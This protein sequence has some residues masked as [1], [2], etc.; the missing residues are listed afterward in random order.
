MRRSVMLAAAV[1]AVACGA[2]ESGS[3]ATPGGAALVVTGSLPLSASSFTAVT[4]GATCQAGS[5]TFGMAYT[6]LFASDQPGICA[7][8]QRNQDRANARSVDLTVVRIDPS[9]PTATVTP[10]RYPVVISPGALNAYALLQVSQNDASCSPSDIQA[11][12][13]SIEVTSFAGGE[14]RGTVVAILPGGGKITGAFDARTCAVTFPGDA[15]SGGF[16][17]VGLTCAP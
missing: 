11:I 13:G 16:G 10:G 8:L 9:S 3:V 17:P 14:I 12:A 7:Y 15:C 1:V 4:G 5:T 6:A 2:E